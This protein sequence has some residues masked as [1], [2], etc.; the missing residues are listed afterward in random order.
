MAK[1]ITAR[2]S[3][4]RWSRGAPS[5]RAVLAA[6]LLAILLV[7]T[8]HVDRAEARCVATL[9]V[10][11]PNG[12]DSDSAQPVTAVPGQTMRFVA[13][14][15][16]CR[17]PQRCRL[18]LF[19]G[20]LDAAGK[21]IGGRLRR[22]DA[23]RPGDRTFTT[24]LRSNGANNFVFRVA[25]T[26]GKTVARKSEKVVGSWQPPPPPPPAPPTSPAPPMVRHLILTLTGPAGSASQDYD[27][28][29]DVKTPKSAPGVKAN[30]TRGERITGT[31]SI[32]GP[33]AP[34]EVLYVR[35]QA[36]LIYYPLCTGTSSCTFQVPQEVPA[37]DRFDEV[38]AMIC[39][40]PP[41]VVTGCND[42]R[43]VEVDADWDA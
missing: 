13:G 43:I 40:S 25:I 22:I 17:L 18:R 31:A 1:P 20:R 36:N 35:G 32:D 7:A 8:I 24:T 37:A 27:L 26:C 29:A 4:T 34:G 10:F 6:A 16:G 42:R 5:P 38:V 2:E 19:A 21:V 41:T 28:V 15:P 3:G 30:S 14:A 12:Q 9:H 39:S 33:L 23:G 11:G